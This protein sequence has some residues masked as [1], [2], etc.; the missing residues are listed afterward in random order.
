MISLCYDYRYHLWHHT[1]APGSSRVP[2]F[3]RFEDERIM[4]LAGLYDEC[5]TAADPS[6]VTWRFALVTTGD[7]SEMKWLKHRQPVILSDDA[8]VRAWL[9]VSSIARSSHSV[10]PIT[11]FLMIFHKYY[12]HRVQSNP[13]QPSYRP[14]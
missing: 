10:F 6:D 3:V 13:V 1:E 11:L 9:D 5:S 7:N 14:A 12:I 8:D 4:F 2:Y